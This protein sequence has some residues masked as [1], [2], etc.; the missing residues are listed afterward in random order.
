MHNMGDSTSK[1]LA[2]QTC[3]LE[4]FYN[5]VS[6]DFLVLNPGP[7]ALNLMDDKIKYREQKTFTCTFLTYCRYHHLT[8]A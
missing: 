2:F 4:V 6:L 5:N 1:W 7:G 8:Q 3:S